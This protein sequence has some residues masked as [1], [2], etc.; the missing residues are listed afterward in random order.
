LYLFNKWPTGNNC[1]KPSFTLFG[2]G[3]DHRTGYVKELL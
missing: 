1:G 3:T 2:T